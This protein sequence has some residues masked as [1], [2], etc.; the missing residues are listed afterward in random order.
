MSINWSIPLDMNK[1]ALE[2]APRIRELERE[3]DDL[4][5]QRYK[6]LMAA[7]HLEA[8]VAYN[9]KTLKVKIDD[10]EISSPDMVVDL[11]TLIDLLSFHGYDA[12]PH[13]DAIE[14]GRYQLTRE[15]VD[16]TVE[17]TFEEI[18]NV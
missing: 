3:L 6:L 10:W 13:I 11:N 7:N 9:P 17:F 2:L 16:N 1:R 4:R 18:Q 14:E 8:V 5:N 15:I 12:V